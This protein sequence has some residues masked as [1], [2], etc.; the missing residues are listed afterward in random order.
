MLEISW[1]SGR[2]LEIVW[3]VSDRTWCLK[4]VWMVSQ[5]CLEGIFGMYVWHVRCLDVSEGHL[6]TSQVRIGKVRTDQV[7]TGRDRCL[8]GS[9]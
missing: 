1:G 7:R 5:R 8:E 4:S 9:A 2:C 6:R 3:R